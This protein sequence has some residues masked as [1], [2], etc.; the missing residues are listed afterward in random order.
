MPNNP[1]TGPLPFQPPSQ[2]QPATGGGLPA[3]YFNG[4]AS[5]PG[6]LP[7][8]ATQTQQQP[9]RTPYQDTGGYQGPQNFTAGAT[10]Y[11]QQHGINPAALP[12]S[13]QGQGQ[14]QGSAT[15]ASPSSGPTAPG[16]GAAGGGLPSS[17]GGMPPLNL[18]GIPPMYLPTRQSQNML[19]AQ[20][21]KKAS[22][23]M[24]INR[25]VG[26]TGVQAGS[27]TILRQLANPM[28]SAMKEGALGAANLGID[29]QLMTDQHLLRYVLGNGQADIGAQR[30]Q[31][32][33]DRIGI[34]GQQNVSGAIA[35]L[36]RMLGG[37][38]NTNSLL[39]T[40]GDAFNQ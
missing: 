31:A 34:E 18:A 33:R 9:Q 17:G 12:Q 15:A 25:L 23:G 20:A 6:S 36:L 30:A 5:A 10:A 24:E 29:D 11:M 26:N 21:A 3:T 22:P 7:W 2:Y 28:L 13:W 4:S 19:M 32:G 39:S 14:G 38:F 1:W 27:G 37:T 16:S 40:F 35:D 8:S